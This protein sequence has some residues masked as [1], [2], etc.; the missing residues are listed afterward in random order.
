MIRHLMLN[1]TLESAIS[2]PRFHHQLMPMLL[3]IESGMDLEVLEGLKHKGHITTSSKTKGGFGSITVI[4][5]DE[6][7]FVRAMNDPRRVGSSEVF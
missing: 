2:A 1:Q 6:T 5:R 3:Y 7:G 4:S